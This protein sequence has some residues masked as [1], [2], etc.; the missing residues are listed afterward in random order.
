MFFLINASKKSIQLEI[1]KFI[2][3]AGGDVE[4][5]KQ[6]L[7]KARLNIMPEGFQELNNVWVKDFYKE[8][9]FNTFKEY[10][11]LAIDGTTFELPY[12]DELK[13][14][15]GEIKNNH[16]VLEKVLGRG[17]ILYDVENNLVIDGILDKYSSNERNMAVSHINKLLEFK[18]SIGKD[19]KDLIIFD[20]GYPSLYLIS[21]MMNRNIDFLMRITHSFLKETNEVILND[22]ERDEIVEIDISKSKL[23]N[24]IRNKPLREEVKLGDKIKLRVLKIMLDSGEYEYLI[25]SIIEDRNFKTN[26][27]K[28]LYF[29]RWGVETAYDK[30]K[31][32]LEIENFSGKKAIVIKQEFYINLLANNICSG[33][34]VEAQKKI[35]EESKEKNLKYE[36]KVNRNYALGAVKNKTLELLFA[37]PGAEADKLIEKLIK[38]LKKN[39]IPIR[40]GR[41]FPRERKKA[42]KQKYCLT[43]KSV[44]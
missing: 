32:T 24:S 34:V 38:R 21:Y 7:C 29:K 22:G 5:S 12:T 25:T 26:I 28:E 9:E 6:A 11:L 13:E 14:E 39:K 19:T 20:R 17:S 18:S 36:Y 43:R 42:N 2:D 15:Y 44:I 1:D 16:G 4:Y 30:L 40:E 8:E 23:Q 27:F 10:R 37:K 33:F 3:K 35:D 31:N 41:K